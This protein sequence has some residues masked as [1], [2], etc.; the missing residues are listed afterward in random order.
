LRQK[1]LFNVLKI[2]RA[3][4][5]TRRFRGDAKIGGEKFVR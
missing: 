5:P 3:R 4:L 1:V 2:N